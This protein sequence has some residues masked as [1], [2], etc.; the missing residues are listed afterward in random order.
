MY[1]VLAIIS[2]EIYI[3]YTYW[4]YWPFNIPV[5]YIALCLNYNNMHQWLATGLWFPIIQWK[6]Y[7]KYNYDNR[8]K[9]YLHTDY[10]TLCFTD[11][12]TYEKRTSRGILVYC[13]LSYISACIEPIVFVVN[14]CSLSNS[15]V[16]KQLIY[17]TNYICKQ[18][19]KIANVLMHCL[20]S[21]AYSGVLYF[22][23]TYVFMFL[24]TCCDVRYDFRMKTMFGSINNSF[25]KQIT[26][27]NK[28]KKLARLTVSRNYD[29]WN[30]P[31]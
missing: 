11:C 12:A 27:A 13:C 19:Q 1:L 24:V 7:S 21:V 18:K 14:T 23:Q 20:W 10:S 8:F 9:R 22:V 4:I 15:S 3:N 2:K 29:S 17:K 30:S 31:W 25:I 5:K 16:N 6:G 26:Y 28:N